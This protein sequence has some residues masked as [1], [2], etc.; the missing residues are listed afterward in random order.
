MSDSDASKKNNASGVYITG[1]GLLAS[2]VIILTSNSLI[3]IADTLGSALDFCSILFAYLTLQAI[4]N[5]DHPAFDYGLGKL[6]NLVSIVIGIFILIAVFLLVGMAGYR[7]Y[8]PRHLE[9]FGIIIALIMATGFSVANTV[10]YL[11]SMRVWRRSQSPVVYAQGRVFLVKAL[12]DAAIVGIFVTCKIFDGVWTE[13]LDTV[14]AFVLA[15]VMIRSGWHLIRYAVRDLLD[16]SAA[17]PMQLAINR[18]LADH[19][20]HYASFVKVRSRCAGRDFFVEIFLGFAATTTMA[21]I[22]GLT[23]SMRHMI[24]DEFPAA[25]VEVIPVLQGD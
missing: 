12:A 17:E 22:A 21:E 16:H 11:K 5:G 18:Q 19:F 2:I 14:A 13:Y 24:R 7:V 10:L 15:L 1:L 4:R 23:E 3:M 9:G 25:H 20:S 6:E 8:H